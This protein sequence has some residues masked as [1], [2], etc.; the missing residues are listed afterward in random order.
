E[1][2]YDNGIAG[3]DNNLTQ[4]TQHVD[5]ST[6]RVTTFLYDWRDRQTD[7]DG[8]VDFYQKVYFDNLNRQ[9]RTEPYNTTLNGNLIA[10]SDTLFDD[11]N[12]VYQT[13][14]YGVDP[15]TGS[16]G[17]SLVDNTWYDPAGNVLKSLPSGAQLFSKM[18]YDGLGR[19]I[20]Q[21]SGYDLTETSYANAGDV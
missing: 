9:I 4:T 20:T 13:I 21:Y 17:N 1:Q 11:Q 16:I 15:T 3:G 7:T 5:A 19:T 18:V 2:Q 10:R 8:E 14:R 12:R 6:T